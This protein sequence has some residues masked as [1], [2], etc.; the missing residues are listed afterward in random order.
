MGRSGCGLA[1]VMA[2]ASPRAARK[3]AAATPDLP[4]PMTRVVLIRYL[5]F[6]VASDSSAKM[7]AMIQKRTTTFVSRHPESSKW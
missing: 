2:T 1:S 4:A 6:N 5:N 3:F 7:M